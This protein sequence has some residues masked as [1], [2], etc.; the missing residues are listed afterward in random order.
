MK[1][2]GNG[3]LPLIVLEKYFQAILILWGLEVEKKKSL[4]FKKSLL[5]SLLSIHNRQAWN[6]ACNKLRSN[7]AS[8]QAFNG[9]NYSEY[10]AAS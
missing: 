8:S 2:E 10:S 3:T 9:A 1:P 7:A 6:F 5:K 4:S